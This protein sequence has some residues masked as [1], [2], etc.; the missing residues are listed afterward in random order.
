MLIIKRKEKSE[1]AT[2]MHRFRGREIELTV[3][4]YDS[5]EIR[6]LQKKHTTY[7]FGERPKS[8]Q[9]ERVPVVDNEAFG[10]DLIDTL[11]VS[12]AGVGESADKPLEVTRENKLLLCGL[13]PDPGE[14]SL[15]EVIQERAKAL[16][17]A[18]DVEQKELEKK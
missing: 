10:R 14:P 12:F 5:D 18:I 7:V 9:L 17:A 8:R 2:F 3:A 1:P 15:L 4:P 16:A 6:R 13:E 11:L